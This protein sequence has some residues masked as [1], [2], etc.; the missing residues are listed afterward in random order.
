MA[1]PRSRTIDFAVYLALKV[2]ACALLM[3][4]TA[5][6]LGLV[7]SLSQVAYRF[8]RR[9]R[10]VARDNLRH[11]FGNR[12]SEAQLTRLVR[13]VYEHFAELLLE[14]LLIPRRLRAKCLPHFLDV[15]EGADYLRAMQSGRPIVLVTA[16]YGN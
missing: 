15:P 13:G 2:I 9:H 8:D 10:T 5:W 4:P 14:M 11:A 1:K 16:H 7:R 3:M 6:A 12:Y